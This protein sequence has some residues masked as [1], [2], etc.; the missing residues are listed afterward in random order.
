MI[1][2]VY[3][4][5]RTSASRRVGWQTFHRTAGRAGQGLG[6]PRGGGCEGPGAAARGGPGGGWAAARERQCQL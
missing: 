6:Q 5:S 1:A 2:E 4:G 3:P